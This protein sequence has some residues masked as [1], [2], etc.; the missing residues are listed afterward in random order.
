MNHLND[1]VC[2]EIM[3]FCS[4]KSLGNMRL[5]CRYLFNL[6]LSLKENIL[7][8]L[9]GFVHHL[10]LTKSYKRTVH[11]KNEQ[12]NLGCMICSLMFIKGSQLHILVP[13]PHDSYDTF[14]LDFSIEDQF[15]CYQIFYLEKKLCVTV[16][17]YITKKDNYEIKEIHI[18]S[19]TIK[20]I[21]SVYFKLTTRSLCGTFFVIRGKSAIVQFI[22]NNVLNF[23][24]FDY[25]TH[26]NLFS[27][28]QK[29][30]P[31]VRTL[32]GGEA[33]ND[34]FIEKYLIQLFSTK[35]P[36]HYFDAKKLQTLRFNQIGTPVYLDNNLLVIRKPEETDYWWLAPKKQNILYCRLEDQDITHSL[37]E[38][39]R[40][41]CYPK[42]HGCY[43]SNGQKF[44]FNDYSH[45][46]ID[47]FPIS[48][49]P[50]TTK[51]SFCEKVEKSEFF[52]D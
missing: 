24:E 13:Y 16:R 35:L 34:I 44:E 30:K 7:H 14:D 41:W 8:V 50:Y 15:F 1:L 45:S 33:S 29:L 6:S 37:I 48:L 5:T 19:N 22:D 36:F 17:K 47:I 28:Q 40:I 4:M 10:Y 21:D 20:C 32:C 46:F 27:F 26:K 11:D 38:H 2:L 31:E 51:S 49:S 18:S 42:T 39:N 52:A 43:L 12:L 3:K 9:M 23:Q 25:F